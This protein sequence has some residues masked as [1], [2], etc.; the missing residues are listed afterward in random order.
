MSVRL[1]ITRYLWNQRFTNHT[2]GQW[3]W[4]LGLGCLRARSSGALSEAAQIVLAAKTTL[5][6][7]KP[8]IPKNF[9]IVKRLF[10]CIAHDSHTPGGLLGESRWQR[11]HLGFLDFWHS[12]DAHN[13][14]VIYLHR[15]PPPL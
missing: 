14:R 10:D 15:P 8:N 2:M 7:T 9:V 6:P 13:V 12:E 5:S 3:G 4:Y 11:R 1:R